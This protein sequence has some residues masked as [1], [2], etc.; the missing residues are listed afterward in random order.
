MRTNQCSYVHYAGLLPTFFM[1]CCTAGASATF[2]ACVSASLI[3][4]RRANARAIRAMCQRLRPMVSPPSTAAAHSLLSPLWQIT[5]QNYL[6]QIN[7]KS[8]LLTQLLC[9]WRT[10]ITMQN[11]YQ[12]MSETAAAKIVTSWFS[13]IP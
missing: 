11:T 12:L 10:A 2:T 4:R 13:F 8:C 9:C 6:I 3:S 1:R 7:F 5:C